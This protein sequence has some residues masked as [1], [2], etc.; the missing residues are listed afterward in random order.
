MSGIKVN[1][2]E[3]VSDGRLKYAVIAARYNGKWVWC[4][5]RE[6]ATFE[7]PGG[8]R[9][10]GENI[11]DTA[12][13]ELYEETG[14]VR[15][16]IFPVCVYSV[17]RDG[18]ENFGMLY[19]SEIYE[20]EAE[21]HSEIEC[22]RLFDDL[23]EELTYPDIQPFLFDKVRSFPA[24]KSGLE[25]A[26]MQDMQRVLQKKYYDK[27]GGLSPEKA[28]DKLLWLYGELGEAADVIKKNGSGKIMSDE[29]L[30]RHFIEEMC[31]VMMYYN[32]VLLCFDIS[33]QELEKVYYEKHNRNMG[34]W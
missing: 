24:V 28:R 33:P 14:A 32:D 15:Y 34:R 17:D 3:S 18:T 19:F 27:W 23:P 7:I 30:R 5:H 11:S 21:L 8:H 13:R 20:L 16:D 4:R 29:A 1:F 26:K 22:I 9:E 31:D 10:A 12:R 6:R 2:Y 25:L